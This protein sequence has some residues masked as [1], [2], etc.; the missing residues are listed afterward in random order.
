MST[1]KINENLQFFREMKNYTQ[2]YMAEQ[3]GISQPQYN[4]IENGKTEITIDKLE[5]IANVLEVDPI[6]LLT[7]NKQLLFKNTFK[8]SSVGHHGIVNVTGIEQKYFKERIE[9]LEDVIIFLREL[10]GKSTT[11]KN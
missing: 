10:L 7:F 4:N 1:I 6:Q 2:G 3:I 9:F 5:K 8:D 11:N